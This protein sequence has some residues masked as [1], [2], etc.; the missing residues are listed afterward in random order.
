MW[1]NKAFVTV[2]MF[3]GALGAGT[4]T[5]QYYSDIHMGLSAVLTTGGCILGAL[6]GLLV[7]IGCLWFIDVIAIALSADNP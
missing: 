4:E 3:I 5:A 2:F 1:F 7:A 6:L